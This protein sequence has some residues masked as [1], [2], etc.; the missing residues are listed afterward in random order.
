MT[1]PARHAGDDGAD[2]RRERQARRRGASRLRARGK[3]GWR[4]V[5]PRGRS[6]CYRLKVRSV[7]MA[8]PARAYWKGY[9]KLSLVTCPIAL[10]PAS[11]LKEKVHFHQINSRTGH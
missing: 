9:L 4:G 6:S 3:C 10:Y 7:V 11:S 2:L 5:E 1:G 8:S